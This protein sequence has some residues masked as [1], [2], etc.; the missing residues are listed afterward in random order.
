MNMTVF[1]ERAL[2]DLAELKSQMRSLMGNGQPGRIHDLEALVARHQ[3]FVQ[4]VTAL[5]LI[6]GPLLA[7]LQVLVDFVRR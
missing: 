4:R 5:A 3:S 1:E 7:A 6:V 2:A